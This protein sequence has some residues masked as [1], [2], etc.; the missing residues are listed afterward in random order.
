L[1]DDIEAYDQ[2]RFITGVN[3]GIVEFSTDAN[4]PDEAHHDRGRALDQSSPRRLT[5]KQW[6]D[7]FR[8]GGYATAPPSVT[9]A[10]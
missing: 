10:A 8:A 5:D 1:R 7:A 9:Y 3:D 4:R 6:L 2:T